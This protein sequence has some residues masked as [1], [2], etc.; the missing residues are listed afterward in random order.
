MANPG[1]ISQ[2]AKDGG[3]LLLNGSYRKKS[4]RQLWPGVTGLSF[5]V[6]RCPLAGFRQSIGV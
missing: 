5:E 6:D 4:P 3:L 2:Q 1:S